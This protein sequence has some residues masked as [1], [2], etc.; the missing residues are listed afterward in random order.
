MLNSHFEDYT[1]SKYKQQF[2]LPSDINDMTN[3]IFYGASGTGK[4]TQMLKSIQPLSP[5]KLKYEKR[6]NVTFNK[7]IYLFKISDIHYEVD[8]ALLGC[9]SK[10][11]WHDIYMQIVD[12]VSSKQE[13]NGIIVCKN[14]HEIHSE[15]LE[16]FYSYMQY[17]PFLY[18]NL[19]FI[20]LTNQI[21]FIPDPILNSCIVVPSSK[22]NFL[23]D[24]PPIHMPHKIICDK[25]V[26]QM[27]DPEKL[28]FV[29]LRD[30]LY[31]ILIYNLDIHECIYY[32]VS[33]LNCRGKIANMS[34]T[35]KQVYC[36]FQFYNNN[37]RPI[38][39]L[40]KFV[41]QLIVPFA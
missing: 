28:D 26:Q 5:S 1:Q 16:N 27:C 7:D 8:L 4:Y 18:I 11:L 3:L 10:L 6:L 38:Y 13:K 2:Q 24:C 31:D 40:E 41:L 15:L 37:Y 12:V 35:M 32:I 22:N 33:E 14:F 39:H 34:E 29:K 36:F 25:V 30:V 9:N 23:F 21:S 19:K 17:N 20:L